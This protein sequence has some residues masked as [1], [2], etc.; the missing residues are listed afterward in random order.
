MLKFLVIGILEKGIGYAV[1]S[2]FFLP[3]QGQIDPTIMVRPR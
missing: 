3:Q 1:V 2:S